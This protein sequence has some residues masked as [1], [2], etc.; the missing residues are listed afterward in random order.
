MA[1]II[2]VDA[3]GVRKESFV[4]NIKASHVFDYHKVL[5]TVVPSIRL[6]A[7][8]ICLSY[9][10]ENRNTAPMIADLSERI[11][12]QQI[13]LAIL[14]YRRSYVA[15]IGTKAWVISQLT[16]KDLSL[17]FYDDA[18][19]H[20]FSTYQNTKGSVRTFLVRSGGLSKE[21]IAK[22]SVAFSRALIHLPSLIKFL[23][24]DERGAKNRSRIHRLLYLNA[25][26]LARGFK[27]TLSGPCGN[28][29]KSSAGETID[30]LH[31]DD[32]MSSIVVEKN[33]FIVF[34]RYYSNRKEYQ[35]TAKA[36]LDYIKEH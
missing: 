30:V 19:D 12:Q 1:Q 32:Q 14:V 16:R 10:G 23:R 34:H 24:G 31:S 8:S 15:E 20:L 27:V 13:K 6:P 36:L 25:V 18:I 21:E 3:N 4:P 29:L 17:S 35:E 26:L 11:K 5:D 2:V 33:D 7:D 22:T 9:V 28:Q